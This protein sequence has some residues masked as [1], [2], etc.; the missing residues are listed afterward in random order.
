MRSQTLLRRLLIGAGVV[1]VVVIVVLGPLL[2]SHLT[3]AQKQPALATVVRQSFPVVASASVTLQPAQLVYLNFSTQ[4]Q[5]SAI[6]V[7]VGQRVSKGQLLAKLNDVGQQASL[8]LANAAVSAARHQLAV[9]NASGSSALIASA[10]YQIASANVLLV[11]AQVDE[12]ATALTAPEAGTVFAV[13][14]AVGEGV[15]ASGSDLSVPGA[16][17]ASGG[18][19]AIDDGADYV[20]WAAFSESDVSRLRVGQTGTVRVDPLPN[21]SVDCK[22]TYIAPSPTLIGGVSKY[23]V[24]SALTR[25]DANFRYGYTG[26]VS[27][28][29]AYADNVL[30][31][32]SQALFSSANG[33]LQVD[34]W[35]NKSAYATTVTIGLVGDT[36]TEITSGL[37]AGEQVVLSPAGQLS[38]PSSPGPT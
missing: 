11:H 16:P 14:G 38:V 27:I 37:H 21:L 34:V 1:V 12:A 7:E 5:V 18:F 25:A 17:I 9:A 35:Y 24:E 3:K 6:Y 19:I 29:V 4:G 22:I 2:L 36:L 32:P 20:A 10:D 13:S 30:A 31:V 33:A 26:T 8:L 15:A 28:D 23:Y